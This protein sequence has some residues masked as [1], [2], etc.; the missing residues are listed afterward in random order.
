MT[1]TYKRDSRGR[2]AGGGGGSRR[3]ASKPVQRGRNRLTRDNAGRITSIGGNGATARGGRL[4]T[5]SGKL[6]AIQTM[7]IKGK[8][9][10][11]I[12][13]PKD[14]KPG[15]VTK[16]ATTKPAPI[17]KLKKGEFAARL[18][19]GSVITKMS[20]RNVTH[21]VAT[22]HPQRGVQVFRWSGSPDSSVKELQRKGWAPGEILVIPVA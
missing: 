18:P 9:S 13:K 4:R 12:S 5:A 7:T 2:F 8:R 16:K 1:R 19:D 21:V 14:L 22:R 10:N 17:P 15:T 6:R 3:P 20:K 11:S